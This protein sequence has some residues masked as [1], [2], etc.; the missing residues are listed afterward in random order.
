VVVRAV[1]TS[2]SPVYTPEEWL[3]MLYGFVRKICPT[4]VA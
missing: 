1:G 2:S 3:N 4:E